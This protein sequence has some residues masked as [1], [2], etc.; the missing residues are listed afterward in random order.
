MIWSDASDRG[1]G[2]NL[3]DQF[4][5][6]IWSA[7][8]A[9]LSVNARELLAA[10]KGLLAFQD[11]LS[12]RVVALFCDNTTAVSY[13]RRQ[14]GTHSASL[15]SI[16]QR[17]LRW[18][19]LRE[20]SLLP[21]FVM[22][23]HNVVADSLSRPNQIIGSEW[24]LNSQVFDLVRKRWP[25]NI[26]LFA[27][28]LNHRCGVYFAPIWDPMSAGTDAMLQTWDHMQAY[29]FPP[30]AM[31]Q[32]VLIKLRVSTNTE[33]TLIA[34][35]WRQRVWFPDL[36]DLLVAPPLE[37]PLRPDLL[38]QPLFH[39]FHLNPGMLRLHAWRLSSSSLR[40]Q[41][42]LREWLASF[43]EREESPL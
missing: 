20:I 31:I 7:E 12:G 8:E 25:V 16:A 5:S 9:L 38:H 23:S 24:T 11:F 3:T 13:L 4:I 34:P 19:E 32:L 18:A 15:N 35:L 6:G 17:I 10:E 22:G 37:L 39:R 30:M 40:P 29:A 26:D 14:G 43:R 36:L 1:W 41:D 28:S 2:A 33:L 27:T 21:Q 42:S